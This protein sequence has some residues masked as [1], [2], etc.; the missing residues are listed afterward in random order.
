MRGENAPRWMSE[1]SVSDMT[2][3]PVNTLRDWRKKKHGPPFSKIGRLVRYSE[4]AVDEWLLSRQEFPGGPH[5]R[6]PQVDPGSQTKPWNRIRRVV[7]GVRVGLLVSD[8]LKAQLEA[9]NL[10][11]IASRDVSEAAMI[12]GLLEHTMWDPFGHFTDE[13]LDEILGSDK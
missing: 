4:V 3:I 10:T 5:K 12:V 2:E 13:E 1:Q 6:Q 11:E 7:N 9:A 8:A